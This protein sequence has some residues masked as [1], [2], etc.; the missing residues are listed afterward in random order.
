MT[1]ILPT[2]APAAQTK[3]LFFDVPLFVHAQRVCQMLIT[4]TMVPDHFRGPDNLGNCMIALNYAHRVGIDPF[5]AMQKMYIIHG[6]PGVETQLQ[7]A[8]LNASGRFSP[9]KYKLTGEGMEMKCVA[10]ATELQSKEVIE[11]P[12]VSMALAKREGWYDKKG[13]K[14][15]TMPEMMLH[16]R[17]AAFFIRVHS[18]ETTL[19]VLTP[20]ELHDMGDVI[21]VTPM[22]VEQEIEAQANT[23]TLDIEPEK[24][25]KEPTPGEPV[26]AEMTEAEKQE[27]LKEEAAQT[28]ATNECGF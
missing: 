21:D 20:E 13:S 27:I 28:E 15:K 10:Y 3:S 4:S 1:N 7:I 14:W 5:M 26:D 22:S 11:G 9:L 2:L 16:Y 12:E 19:G 17:A 23:E 6:K 8:L 24:I 18:P 25:S